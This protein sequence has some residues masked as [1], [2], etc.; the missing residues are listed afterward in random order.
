MKQL[1][2]YGILPLTKNDMGVFKMLLLESRSL[3]NFHSEMCD[4]DGIDI[5]RNLRF[6]VRYFQ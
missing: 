6:Q 2:E 3:F 4:R 5:I 1:T